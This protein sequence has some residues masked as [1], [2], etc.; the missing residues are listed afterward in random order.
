MM[1]FLL[2]SPLEKTTLRPNPTNTDN[3]A[4]YTCSARV[5]VN[6]FLNG[7]CCGGL[8]LQSLGIAGRLQGKLELY[9]LTGNVKHYMH[10][11]LVWGRRSFH[12]DHY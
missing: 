6:S 2:V 1:S 10:R 3:I 11:S 12:N 9:R 5:H 4:F 7:K 8:L